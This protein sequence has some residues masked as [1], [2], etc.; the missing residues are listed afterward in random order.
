MQPD[1]KGI[2][3]I[4]D[5]RVIGLS[6]KL[7]WPKEFSDLAFFRRM[8]WGCNLVMGRKT[9]SGLGKSW[10][11]N[12]HIYVLTKFNPFG[13]TQSENNY[14]AGKGTTTIITSVDDLPNAEVWVCGGR[15]VY[16]ALM[17]QMTEFLVTYVKGSFEG[18]TV[19]PEF[20]HLFPNKSILNE[21]EFYK[22][23]RMT[24]L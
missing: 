17:P 22:T 18:D 6:D 15:M 12:R 3:A 9:Y 10:L 20:E 7:P 5:N 21:T 14:T 1:Y 4:A 19:M 2:I 13:W 11:P 23:V 8:T 16:E 24:K